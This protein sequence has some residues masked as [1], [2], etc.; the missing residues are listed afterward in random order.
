MNSTQQLRQL[1]QQLGL[2]ASQLEGGPLH[3]R[4]PIDGHA[5]GQ[6]ATAAPADVDAVFARSASAFKRWR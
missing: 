6:V 4:S 1:W 5:L 3:S 2:P